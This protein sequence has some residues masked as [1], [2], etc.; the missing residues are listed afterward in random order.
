[1]RTLDAAKSLQIL[2]DLIYV[3]AEYIEQRVIED[4]LNWFPKLNPAGV[5]C[6]DDWTWN[7]VSS[8]VKKAAEILNLSV[9]SVQNFWFLEK[10]T[11]I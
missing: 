7:E 4:I 5:L 3:D 2:A 6:G 1:M 10:I 8:G 11:V 9:K